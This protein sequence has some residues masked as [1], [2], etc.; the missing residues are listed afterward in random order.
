[1]IHRHSLFNGREIEDIELLPFSA[2]DPPNSADEYFCMCTPPQLISICFDDFSH[3][4]IMEF[5]F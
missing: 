1:M 5:L 4:E 3:T 2:L